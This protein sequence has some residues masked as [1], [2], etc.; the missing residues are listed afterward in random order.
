MSESVAVGNEPGPPADHLVPEE[1]VAAFESLSPVEKLKLLEIEKNY[2][3]GTGFSPT[4][5]LHE[6]LYRALVGRRKCP[7]GVAFMAF[8]VQTM[9]GVAYHERQ[10]LARQ[11]ALEGQAERAAD[12]LSPEEHLLEREAVDVVA[13]IH[14]LFEG[15]EQA[16]MVL[17]GWAD[18]LRGKELRD[19]V[20]VD[21]AGLDYIIKRIRRVMKKRYPNGWRS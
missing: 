1:V 6:A 2:L 5:L 21:Q 14:A 17:L 10:R 9:R 3:R 19:C 4:D 15:D 13:A 18:D 8:L 20:G 7:R 12:Q 11:V 16:R